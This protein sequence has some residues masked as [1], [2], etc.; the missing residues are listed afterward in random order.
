METNN[1]RWQGDQ[2]LIRE[3][4]T[5]MIGDT[6]RPDDHPK[7]QEALKSLDSII[8]GLRMWYMNMLPNGAG[9]RKFLTPEQE[10]FLE[11]AKNPYAYALLKAQIARRDAT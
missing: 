6:Y 7:M 11:N 8:P 2:Q 10:R 5:C 3:V 1:R 4:A 9:T